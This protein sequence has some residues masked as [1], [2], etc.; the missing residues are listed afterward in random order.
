M[1]PTTEVSP[2][3]DVTSIAFF[4]RAKHYHLAAVVTDNEHDVQVFIE[5]A[6]MFEA[7]AYAFQRIEM[8]HRFSASTMGNSASTNKRQLCEQSPVRSSTPQTE[9][10]NAHSHQRH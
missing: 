4:R 9:H 8:K 5:L 1:N 2:F 3:K 7:I 6:A 10:P